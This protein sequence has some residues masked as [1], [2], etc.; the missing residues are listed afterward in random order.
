MHELWRATFDDRFFTI[1]A[2]NFAFPE[3]VIP[4]LCSRVSA[5][6]SSWCSQIRSRPSSL[7]LLCVHRQHWL[8][9]LPHEEITSK[10]YGTKGLENWGAGVV[11]SISALWP[12]G[13]ESQPRVA[14]SPGPFIRRQGRRK[15]IRHGL[16]EQWRRYC[17]APKPKDAAVPDGTAMIRLIVV[18][19][20]GGSLFLSALA[21]DLLRPL[22]L[23]A[24][25]L[26]CSLH[27]G[28][29]GFVQ[30]R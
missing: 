27:L 21:P 22:L 14:R 1:P 12:R 23:G 4:L 6:F 19:F 28:G 18:L 11:S 7:S 16:S 10:A 25:G 24:Q 5:G 26:G 17:A 8:D 20:L 29:L 2:A 15:R 13:S 30:A 3:F 9:L